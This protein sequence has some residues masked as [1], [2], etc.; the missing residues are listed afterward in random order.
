MAVEKAVI[1]GQKTF[2]IDQLEDMLS[3]L[4]ADQDTFWRIEGN[5]EGTPELLLSLSIETHPE[6]STPVVDYE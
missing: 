3:D 4:R 5:G 6:F 1:S 2:L